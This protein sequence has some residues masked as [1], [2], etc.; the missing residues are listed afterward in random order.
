M[1][2]F[3]EL[4][5][6][7]NVYG[8]LRWSSTT[9]VGNSGTSI[10]P[11]VLK[12]GGLIPV[13]ITCTIQ[14]F[15]GTAI[16]G[17]DYTLNTTSLTWVPGS[18]AQQPVNITILSG[19]TTGRTLI[20][21]VT[22]VLMN[23]FPG[24]A[25]VNPAYQDITITFTR[26]PGPPGRITFTPPAEIDVKENGSKNFDVWRLDGFDG[27]TSVD[28]ETEDG[29]G[30][31]G[32]DY[33]G[34]SGTVNWTDLEAG[35]KVIGP[36]TVNSV[37]SDKTFKIR[38]SNPS[39]DAVL[40]TNYFLL[41]VTIRDVPAAP[42]EFSFGTNYYM[43]TEVVGSLV[44]AVHRL[45]GKNGAVSVQYATSNGTALSGTHYTSASGTLNWADQDD[46]AKTFNVTISSVDTL[47][48]F[49]ITIFN[50]L[51]G[52]SLGMF[53]IVQIQIQD[54]GA[55]PA[56]PIP[57]VLADDLAIEEKIEHLVHLNFFSAKDVHAVVANGLYTTP[58]PDTIFYAGSTSSFGGGV[59]LDNVDPTLVGIPLSKKFKIKQT[60]ALFVP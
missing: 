36:I 49:N 27:A 13:T 3:F 39:G 51:G 29:T 57:D 35:N 18:N 32:V 6:F 45:G 59:D 14:T 23:G 48:W 38:L 37:S 26:V 12:G 8:V 21:R 10:S 1:P 30:V 9:A 5:P 2:S 17:V 56:T 16:A 53:S 47:R 33:V 55:P 44:V 22:N 50:P 28:W 46:T 43:T 52:A 19:V 54:T 15:G 40:D 34:D 41:T 42:G 7:F 31:D 20:L 25:E 60:K 11:T 24:Y 58:N 4:S